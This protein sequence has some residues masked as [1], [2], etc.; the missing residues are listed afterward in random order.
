MVTF[1][2]RRTAVTFLSVFRSGVDP[3]YHPQDSRLQFHSKTAATL[4]SDLH[5]GEGEER[6]P[7]A[8]QYRLTSR[9]F[10]QT[11]RIAEVSIRRARVK[12]EYIQV[13]SDAF[14]RIIVLQ[15][16]W[17]RRPSPSGNN[18]EF[19]IKGRAA[20]GCQKLN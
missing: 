2:V 6:S 19:E 4:R 10:S 7:E 12:A 16:H 18:R 13:R 11:S 20:E 1:G 5:P 17:E 14:P 8:D 9:S 15:L 3:L